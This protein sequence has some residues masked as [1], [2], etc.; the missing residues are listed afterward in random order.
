MKLETR[1]TQLDRQRSEL[2]KDR[3][4]KQEHRDRLVLRK[5]TAK[6]GSVMPLP[7]RK[8]IAIDIE[9]M[10]MTLR[11]IEKLLVEVEVERAS[12]QHRIQS[13]RRETFNRDE[14]P[15][16]SREIEEAARQILGQLWQAAVDS[17]DE[18]ANRVMA[19][20][21]ELQQDI[22]RIT[23]TAQPR[24]SRAVHLARETTKVV[25]E[26]IERSMKELP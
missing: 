26:I 15:R 24:P 4:A 20:D 11:E 21:K 5:E 13:E 16:R 22:H 8:Q 6:E 19:P 7:E 9:E 3:T 14:R 25:R 23:G 17:T 2:E 18:V 1:A 10:E 12:V